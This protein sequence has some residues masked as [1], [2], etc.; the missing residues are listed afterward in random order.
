[1]KLINFKNAY[2]LNEYRPADETMFEKSVF[3]APEMFFSPKIT[4]KSDVWSLGVTLYYMLY[5]CSPW[6]NTREHDWHKRLI[7]SVVFP[8]D[9]EVP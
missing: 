7:S 4:Q 6:P 5:G 2:N 8:P 9:V 1:V 3:M